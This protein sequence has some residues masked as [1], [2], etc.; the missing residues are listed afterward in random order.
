MEAGSTPASW[1]PKKIPATCGDFLFSRTFW[2]IFLHFGQR[3]QFG[4][5]GQHFSYVN[6]VRRHLLCFSGSIIPLPAQDGLIQPG[7]AVALWIFL[8]LK[9][10]QSFGGRPVAADFAEQVVEQFSLVVDGCAEQIICRV[11]LVDQSSH[12]RAEP[13]LLPRRRAWRLLVSLR[14]ID[15]DAA[16]RTACQFVVEICATTTTFDFVLGR[17]GIKTGGHDAFAFSWDM[18]KIKST[19]IV[20]TIQHFNCIFALNLSTFSGGIS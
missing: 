1:L 5:L 8:A 7:D 14:L 15:I 3:V 19:H 13:V 10:N 12:Q 16:I 2:P 4:L 6:N 9:L 18:H 11:G 20:V 17:L